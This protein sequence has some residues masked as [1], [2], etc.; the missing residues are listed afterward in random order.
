MVT[1]LWATVPPCSTGLMKEVWAFRRTPFSLDQ[2]CT[3]SYRTK[4]SPFT[5]YVP[6]VIITCICCLCSKELYLYVLILCFVLILKCNYLMIYLVTL[7]WATIYHQDVAIKVSHKNI[8]IPGE[9]LA[10]HRRG[11]GGKT[12]QRIISLQGSRSPGGPPRGYFWFSN[13]EHIG[14]YSPPPPQCVLMS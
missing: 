10:F 6:G 12:W 4:L 11:G 9:E 8:I 13:L 2:C 3:F 7:L 1:L 14:Y 5:Y